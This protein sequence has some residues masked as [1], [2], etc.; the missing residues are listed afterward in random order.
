L[1]THFHGDHDFDMPFLLREFY[2]VPRAEP[3]S[4]ICPRGFRERY[5]K[6]YTMAVPDDFE[7]L[8]LTAKLE[9][10][11]IDR[12]REFEIAGYR[13]AVFRVEHEC[14][15]FGFR[16]SRGGRTAAFTGDSTFC[17]AILKLADGADTVFSDVTMPERSA[18]HMGA[19]DIQDLRARFP[20]CRFIP[21]HMGEPVPAI[22]AAA[23]FAVPNDGDVFE[24]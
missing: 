24:I 11:E 8:Y 5:G 7:K 6:L 18:I 2:R 15:A 22:L 13:I 21:T 3:I 10:H 4:I 14:D 20:K 17:D 16:I 12:A 9:I 1:I 19:A 23:G